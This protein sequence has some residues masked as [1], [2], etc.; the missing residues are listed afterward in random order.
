[1]ST[2]VEIIF[3]FFVV[4]GAV[5]AF[6]GSLGLVKFD[7]FYMRLHGPTK[8]S[9]LGLGG[10][11]IASAIYFTATEPIVSVHEVWVT[12]F[13][14]MTA[15]VSAHML[16]KTALNHEMPYLG[17]QSDPLDHPANVHTDQEFDLSGRDEIDDYYSEEE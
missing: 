17:G 14:F 4:L 11:L 16:A 7:D 9:T 10:M 6:I 8:A 12:V 15:P 13:L 3:A 2:A 1:M 5:F